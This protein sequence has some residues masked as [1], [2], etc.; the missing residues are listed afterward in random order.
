MISPIVHAHIDL[1]VTDTTRKVII[2][3]DSATPQMEEEEL[4]YLKEKLGDGKGRVTRE[5]PFKFWT[6]GRDGGVT[7]GTTV[8]L[9]VNCDSDDG[10]MK[11]VDRFLYNVAL[12]LN[13]T[14]LEELE[15]I[16]HDYFEK[17]RKRR[18]T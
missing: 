12:D 1:S 15:G 8:T 11:D 2:F 18:I 5:I 16:A 7:F 14:T 13:L 6:S 10:V 17:T 3:K 9:S 4:A